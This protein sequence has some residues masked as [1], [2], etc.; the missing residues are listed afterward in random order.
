VAPAFDRAAATYRTYVRHDNGTPLAAGQS[1]TASVSLK[2]AADGSYYV[3]VVADALNNNQ[4]ETNEGNNASAASAGKVVVKG[5]PDLTA[6]VLTAD[7]F[8]QT[9]QTFSATW[10]VTDS[11]NHDTTAPGWY[12]GI[13]LLWAQALNRWP[14][15]YGGAF[16]VGEVWHDN[17]TPLKAGQSYTGSGLGYSLEVGGFYYVYV[18]ADYYNDQPETN[19]GNNASAP[20]A[21]T[22]DVIGPYR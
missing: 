10:T 3:Y 12:D 1:Y 16:L 18:V 9:E 21:F 6:S 11:G 4:P 8:V 7:P 15:G 2:F 22:V 20:S 5:E 17:S 14:P 13:F 19:E